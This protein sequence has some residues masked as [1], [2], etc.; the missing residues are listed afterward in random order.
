MPNIFQQISSNVWK[1][2]LLVFL[3]VL[4]IILFGLVFGAMNGDYF[5]LPML[6]FLIAIAMALI[7]YYYSDAIVLKTSGA[8]EAE[9]KK[10]SHLHN[11]VEGLSIGIGIPKPRIFII[12][13]TAINAF[14][15]GRDPS[16]AVIAVTTGA[17][18][19]LNRQE[20][21]GVIAHE[22]SHIKNYD[23][24]LMTILVV[25][26]TIVSLLSDWILRGFFWKSSDNK[27]SGKIVIILLV[28]GIALAILAPFIAT[29]LKLS[30]SRKREYLA[31]ASGALLTHNPIGL[32]NA[33][34][35]ISKDK[36]PLEAANTGTAHLY[37]HNPLRNNKG[38]WLSNLFS[39]HP[40]IE[41]RIKLLE[42]M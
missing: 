8:I 32:A 19:R 12:E 31:D 41:E 36:E 17:I 6:A 15:T 30:V 34:K 26:V 38:Q 18:Q 28:I 39:T 4:F 23:I 16:H 40:P 7:G 13:D 11:I 1:T 27:E 20:L 33:L 3:F 2:R 14:A 9:K 35:K 10:Y 42:S 24:R 21:E 5:F 37:I 25:L 29:L 22:I